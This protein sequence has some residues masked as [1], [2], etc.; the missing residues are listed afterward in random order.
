MDDLLK[1]IAQYPMGVKLIVEWRRYMVIGSLDTI[2]ETDNGLEMDDKGYQE[3]YACLL[4][5]DNIFGE[6]EDSQH[7]SKGDFLE[8]SLQNPPLKI[9]LED[10]T[11]IWGNK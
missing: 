6:I 4:Y 7:F 9:S 5:V 3:F 11:I 8:I 10:G 1:V 2:Y